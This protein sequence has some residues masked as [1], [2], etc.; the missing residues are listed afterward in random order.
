M[1]KFSLCLVLAYVLGGFV[2][3]AQASDFNG[4]ASDL[5]FSQTAGSAQGR[6][7]RRCMRQKYGR[8]YFRGV[9]RA[10]RFHMSQACGG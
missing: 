7:F 10:H 6:A 3:P 2:S 1:K 4:F 5:A 9:P 8:N